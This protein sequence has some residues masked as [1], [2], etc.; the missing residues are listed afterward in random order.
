[1]LRHLMRRHP[2]SPRLGALRRLALQ[3]WPSGLAG[4]HA[5]LLAR[6]RL[7]WDRH[8]RAGWHPTLLPDGSWRHVGIRHALTLWVL[9]RNLSARVG[10]VAG[11]LSWLELRIHAVLRLHRLLGL[12]RLSRL[13]WL[14]S[15]LL[16]LL[17]RRPRRHAWPRPRTT[18]LLLHRGTAGGGIL[19]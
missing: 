2:R 1:V 8:L 12:S 4:G 19:R 15:C 14:R 18:R 17:R 11:L 6:C 5:A 7:P 9:S 16:W 13:P 10:R 3:L